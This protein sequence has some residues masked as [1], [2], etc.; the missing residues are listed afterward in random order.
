[1]TPVAATQAE[2]V[3][4]DLAR[5]PPAQRLRREA[6]LVTE[7]VDATYYTLTNAAVLDPNDDPVEHFCREGWQMLL[8]PAPE[9]DV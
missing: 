4:A 7:H 3:L 9:F 6:A 8:K 1:M 2:S 5:L